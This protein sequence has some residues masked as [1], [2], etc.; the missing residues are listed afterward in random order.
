ML[1]QI[2]AFSDRSKVFM[3]NDIAPKEA[4]WF[5]EIAYGGYN[6]LPKTPREII[7]EAHTYIGKCIFTMNEYII[8]WFLREI[9]QGFLK[10][11]DLQLFCDMESI[12]IDETGELIDKWPGGFFP[13]RA[14]LLFY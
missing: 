3:T 9:G 6:V 4:V 13:Y 8:L 2:Y 12:R 1:T 14:K 11:E 7:E 10:S 5:P